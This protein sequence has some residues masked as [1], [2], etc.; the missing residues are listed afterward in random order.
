VI[1][2]NINPKYIDFLTAIANYIGAD[3]SRLAPVNLK[4][5]LETSNGYL[6]SNK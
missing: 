5:I 2:F 3:T 4:R 1:G 6:P